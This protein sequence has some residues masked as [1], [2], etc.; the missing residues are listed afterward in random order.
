M[1]TARYGLSPYIKQIAVSISKVKDHIQVHLRLYSVNNKVKVLCTTK[2]SGFRN[3]ISFG[4][5]PAFT[6]L[7]FW[8]EQHIAEDEYRLYTQCYGTNALYYRALVS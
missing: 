1:F 3:S 5:L 7:S 6:L 4:R 8:Q 2:I